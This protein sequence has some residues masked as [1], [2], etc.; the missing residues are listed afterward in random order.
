MNTTHHHRFFARVPCLLLA[1]ALLGGTIAARAQ[2]PACADDDPRAPQWLYGLWQFALWP[3]DGDEARPTSTGAMLLE[4]HPEY[5]DG[6]RGHLKR[7]T[8]GNDALAQ[9]SGDV[10]DEGEFALDE[11]ADGVRIDAAWIGHLPPAACGREIRG[12]RHPTGPADGPLMHFVL[13]RAAPAP[14]TTGGAPR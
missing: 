5:T 13:R 6:V 11:S 3:E 4:A 12:Q 7:S 2:A 8:A 9:V 14:A 1:A 10:D